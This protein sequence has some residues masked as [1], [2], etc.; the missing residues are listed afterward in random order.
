MSVRDVKFDIPAN[1]ALKFN[2]DEIVHFRGKIKSIYNIL[3]SCSINLENATVY[4]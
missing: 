4:Q 3:G 2:K 1:L